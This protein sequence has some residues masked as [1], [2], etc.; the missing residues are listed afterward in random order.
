[1]TVALELLECLAVPAHQV[2]SSAVQDPFFGFGK[3]ARRNSL[4][5][6][7]GHDPTLG[8]LLQAGLYLLQDID[9]VCKR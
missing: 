6:Q 5:C 3:P 4:S 1:M 8:D 2:A 9:A 7:T